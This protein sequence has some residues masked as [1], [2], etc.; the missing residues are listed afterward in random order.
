MRQR[1]Q[2]ASQG[3]RFRQRQAN[4]DGGGRHQIAAH[5]GDDGVAD[6]VACREGGLDAPILGGGGIGCDATQ[7]AAQLDLDPISHTHLLIVEDENGQGGRI[8]AGGAERRPDLFVEDHQ[9]GRRAAASD[10]C[11]RAIADGPL[12]FLDK[13]DND[14]A[15]AAGRQRI[16]RNR[17]HLDR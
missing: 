12:F 15:A 3:E 7:G 8:D 4:G 6:A 14:F 17:R 2:G 9:L 16:G 5:G 10:G 1:R 11:H 13:G